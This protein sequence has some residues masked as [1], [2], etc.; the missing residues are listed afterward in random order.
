VLV[1]KA[2]TCEDCAACSYNKVYLG[3]RPR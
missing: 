3:P 2:V 1:G